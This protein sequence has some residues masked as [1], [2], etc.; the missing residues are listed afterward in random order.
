MRESE[1][2]RERERENDD[3]DWRKLVLEAFLDDPKFF[4]RDIFF[5]E[6]LDF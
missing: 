2:E 3:A 4:I 5:G 1:R 6:F